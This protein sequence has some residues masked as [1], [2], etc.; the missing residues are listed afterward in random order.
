MT[1]SYFLRITPAPLRGDPPHDDPGGW[2][3]EP[4]AKGRLPPAPRALGPWIQRGCLLSP[5]CQKVKRLRCSVSATKRLCAILVPKFGIFNR[6]R[7]GVLELG[8]ALLGS[9]GYGPRSIGGWWSIAEGTWRPQVFSSPTFCSPPALLISRGLEFTSCTM[10]EASQ[11]T[12]RQRTPK[13]CD[14]CNRQKLKAG[15]H[16]RELARYVPD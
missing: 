13:A 16:S 12:K 3:L 1:I 4:Q 6:S 5:R 14:R 7:S 2:A 11:T 8:R 9:V 15:L 10:Q